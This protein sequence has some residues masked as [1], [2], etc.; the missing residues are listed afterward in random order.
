MATLEEASPYIRGRM[1]H[2]HR[3][4]PVSRGTGFLAAAANT[5]HTQQIKKQAADRRSTTSNLKEI[6]TIGAE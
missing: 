4:L 2:F 3:P 6:G 1:A 5:V